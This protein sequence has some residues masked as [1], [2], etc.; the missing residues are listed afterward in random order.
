MIQLHHDYLLFET[1]KGQLIPCSAELVAVELV[2]EVAGSMDPELV[3]QA[4]S[5]VLHYFK[6]D[7]GCTTVSVGEFSRVLEKALQAL[8]I[9]SESESEPATE[10]SLRSYDLRQLT[11]GSDRAFELSFFSRLRDEMRTLLGPAPG[12]LRFHG[13]R[14]CVKQMVGTKR[15]SPRCQTLNDQIVEYLRACLATE[16]PASSCGLV[17]R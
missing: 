16:S 12:V 15:W 17:I 10:G 5:A 9:H 11:A 7:L 13:L 1:A 4:A 2:G 6:E 14:E 3:Q 8:G